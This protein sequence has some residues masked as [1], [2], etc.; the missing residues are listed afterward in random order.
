MH[1][2]WS[3]ESWLGLYFMMEWVCHDSFMSLLFST[4][5]LVCSD[6]VG[7]LVHWDG[8]VVYW[9]GQQYT[10]VVLL[11]F[12]WVYGSL[13]WVFCTLVESVVL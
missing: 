8:S 13:N 4:L 12:R 10:E 5:K 1:R 7:S 6:L 2:S 3:F 9:M 11:C